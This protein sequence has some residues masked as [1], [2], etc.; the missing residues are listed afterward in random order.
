LEV[1]ADKHPDFSLIST[2]MIGGR[3]WS[4][5]SFGV[6]ARSSTAH[7]AIVV[8]PR[9]RHRSLKKHTLEHFGRRAA[10]IPRQ[11][12]PERDTLNSRMCFT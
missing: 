10:P 7:L 9:N 12:R 5:R 2:R 6:V 11:Q 1:I 4:S 8:S 3:F